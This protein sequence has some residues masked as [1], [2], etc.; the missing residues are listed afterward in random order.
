MTDTRLLR[1]HHCLGARTLPATQAGVMTY[2][3]ASVQVVHEGRA[4]SLKRAKLAVDTVG[5]GTEC[6]LL[7][8][9]WDGCQVVALLDS[10]SVVQHRAS[11][12]QLLRL[13][14]DCTGHKHP[15]GACCCSALCTALWCRLAIPS[16]ASPS[17]RV[18]HVHTRWYSSWRPQGDALLQASQRAGPCR[19]GRTP[20]G[21]VVQ[22]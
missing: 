17:R 1:H 9:G 19:S 21:A 7:L 22:H 12:P 10:V 11:Q 14:P 16:G 8:D 6:G 5:K 15:N 18:P 13:S 4:A 20:A 2:G 3:A